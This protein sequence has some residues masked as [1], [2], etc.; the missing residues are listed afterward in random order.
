MELQKALE[1]LA[2]FV[3][4]ADFGRFRQHIDPAWIEE[5]LDA[6]G[7]ASVRRRRLPAEPSKAST[8][9][10]SILVHDYLTCY[11]VSMKSQDG[12]SLAALF[13]LK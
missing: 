11:R 2:G 12:S 3:V 6:T 7:K 9:R 8:K 1:S 4:P 10:I 5:A 13:K